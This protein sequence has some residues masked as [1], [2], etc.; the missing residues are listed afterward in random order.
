MEQSLMRKEIGAEATP[1]YNGAWWSHSV[2]ET[3]KVAPTVDLASQLAAERDRTSSLA[4]QMEELKGLLQKALTRKD[5]ASAPPGWSDAPPPQPQAPPPLPAL[6][7]PS[8]RQ[9]S[10]QIP[11]P[12]TQRQAAEERLK[13]EHTAATLAIEKEQ[14][15]MDKTNDKIASQV[16]WLPGK[17]REAALAPVGPPAPSVED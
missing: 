17:A 7:P 6:P 8:Q 9:D 15:D 13:A 11:N 12:S 3:E 5:L 1:S 4:K 10:K 2:E 16:A 14:E